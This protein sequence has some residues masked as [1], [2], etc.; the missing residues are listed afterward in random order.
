MKVTNNGKGLIIEASYFEAASITEAIRKSIPAY[1]QEGSKESADQA[2][3]LLNELMNSQIVE[4]GDE[5][6]D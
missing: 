4:I 1:E 5:T 3:E 2:R 6:N